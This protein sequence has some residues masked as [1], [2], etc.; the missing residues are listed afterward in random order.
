MPLLV[1][2]ILQPSC[3]NTPQEV[4]TVYRLLSNGLRGRLHHKLITEE[5]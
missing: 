1:G 2:I 5:G 3:G 4:R